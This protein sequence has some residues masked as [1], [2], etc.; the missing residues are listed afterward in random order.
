MTKLVLPIDDYVPSTAA[1]DPV[2][3]WRGSADFEQF[4]SRPDSAP[5]VSLLTYWD[6]KRHGQAAPLRTA[7]DPIEFPALLP[8]IFVMEVIDGPPLD[9]RFRLVG[10]DIIGGLRANFTGKTLREVFPLDGMFAIVWQQYRAAISGDVVVRVGV[11]GFEDHR[12]RFRVPISV[13][14]L[15]LRTDPGSERIGQLLGYVKYYRDKM[16][17]VDI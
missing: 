10:T 1:V 8:G 17:R 13:I 15:P 5:F 7:I 16:E 3:L 14:L 2:L 6:E 9:F 11:D 4:L 12:Y